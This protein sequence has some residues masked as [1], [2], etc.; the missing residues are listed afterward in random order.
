MAMQTAVDHMVSYAEDVRNGED[1][2][3]YINVFQNDFN[4]LTGLAN[5]YYQ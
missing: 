1:T 2:T 4:A 3:K 5:L